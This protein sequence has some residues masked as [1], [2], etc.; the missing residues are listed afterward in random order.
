MG[1]IHT[2]LQHTQVIRVVA[3]VAAKVGVEARHERERA[4]TLARLMRELDSRHRGRNRPGGTGKTWPLGGEGR[5]KVGL[6]KCHHQGHT[7]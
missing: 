7:V 6:S 1:S 5:E 3:M 2:G 4:A